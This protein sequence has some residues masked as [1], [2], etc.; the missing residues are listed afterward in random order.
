MTCF[1]N[2][3]TS[4]AS[5]N[6]LLWEAFQNGLISVTISIGISV[7]ISIGISGTIW[8]GISGTIPVT[9]TEPSGFV[10]NEAPGGNFLPPTDIDPSGF[11]WTGVPGGSDPTVFNVQL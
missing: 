1:C 10:C 11:F 8:S 5:W 2:H 3:L 7:T 9:D 4:L 6:I